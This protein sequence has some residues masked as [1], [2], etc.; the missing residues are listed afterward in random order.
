MGVFV[1]ADEIE[2]SLPETG[3]ILDLANLGI[4]GKPPEVLNR[5][6]QHI[7]S[8][9]FACKLGLHAL[10]GQM[11]IDAQLCIRVPEPYDSYLA[12]VLADAISATGSGFLFAAEA[13]ANVVANKDFAAVERAA[14]ASL[15]IAATLKPLHAVRARVRRWMWLR[16]DAR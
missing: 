15:D 10:L 6:E 14:S 16:P 7:R 11:A 1:N 3:A 8:L 9:P 12:S 4:N 2:R 5:I 13:F